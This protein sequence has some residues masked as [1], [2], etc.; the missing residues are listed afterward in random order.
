MRQIGLCTLYTYVLIELYK[1]SCS[2]DLIVF[3]KRTGSTNVYSCKNPISQ[4]LKL[5]EMRVILGLN[6]SGGKQVG[7]TT[8]ST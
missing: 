4:E 5:D 2:I 7:A 8:R 3:N 6:T 1:V